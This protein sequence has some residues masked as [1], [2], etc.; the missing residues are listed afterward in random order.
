[1]SDGRTLPLSSTIPICESDGH[2][3]ILDAERVPASLLDWYLALVRQDEQRRRPHRG[4]GPRRAALSL[5]QN[6]LAETA[7]PTLFLWGPTL[8]LALEAGIGQLLA[9]GTS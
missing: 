8:G 4:G 9:W 5:T 3:K 7:V 2:R 6:L 1:M